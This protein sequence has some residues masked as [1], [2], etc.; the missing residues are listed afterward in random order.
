MSNLYKAP[1]KVH[2]MPD[3]TGRDNYIS[4]SSGGQFKQYAPR[5]QLSP[6]RFIPQHRY[7]SRNT[8]L[9]PLPVHYHADGSGRDAYI[10]TTDGGLSR[11]MNRMVDYKTAF[12]ESLR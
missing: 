6:G 2:Y 8:N 1:N 7:S 9:S 5:K 12:R 4:W 10:A 11:N 3:G